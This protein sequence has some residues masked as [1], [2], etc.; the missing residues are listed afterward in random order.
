MSQP[1]YVKKIKISTDNTVWNDL[2]ATSPSLSIGGDVLDDTN[3]ATN[4]GFRSRCLGISDF[5][6]SADSIWLE[7]NQ[8]LT[9]LRDSKLNRTTLYIQYLPKGIVDG[10]GFTGQVVVESYEMTG[11]VAGLE[12][13]SISLQGNG[14]LTA[15]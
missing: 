10:T 12:T 5:S 9:D 15:V 2:P 11:D 4:A 3:L 7:N 13:V 14:T 8:A 1:A 6:V